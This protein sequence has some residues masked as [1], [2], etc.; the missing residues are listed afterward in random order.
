MWSEGDVVVWRSLAFGH[1]RFAMPHIV[2]EQTSEQVVVWLPGGTPGKMFTGKPLG[3]L[4]SLGEADWSLQDKVWEG[5]GVLKVHRFGRHHSLWHFTEGWYV[6]L[7][8]PWRPTPVGWD[9]RDL[10]LDIVVARDGSWHWKDEEYFS[11]TVARGWITEQTAA[12]VRAE[13][14]RVLE[15]RP[16]PSGWED[17]RPDPEWPL[18]ELPEGWDAL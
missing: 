7:E 17:W 1:I 5:D 2:V 3:E 10:V 9:T 18:P 6:N 13:G 8:E 15:E 12:V 16:W 11:A 14:E 4:A